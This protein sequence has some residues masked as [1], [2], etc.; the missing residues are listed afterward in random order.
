MVGTLLCSFEFVLISE[1]LDQVRNHIEIRRLLEEAST[2]LCRIGDDLR[3]VQD[4][5]KGT[6]SKQ[7][8]V[9]HSPFSESERAKILKWISPEPY[10][11]HHN[12]TKED[13]LVGT[14]N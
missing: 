3:N 12:Q 7:L 1:F 4:N 9:T 14:G 10:I 2:P 6:T 13:V 5:L 8:E 11:L